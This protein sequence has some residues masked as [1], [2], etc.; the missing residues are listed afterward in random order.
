MR[1]KKRLTHRKNFGFAACPPFSPSSPRPP[2]DHARPAA[3]ALLAPSSSLR[4]PLHSRTGR[5]S[6][7]RVA[8]DVHRQT[9]TVR[10]AA[11]RTH[12]RREN[13]RPPFR[14]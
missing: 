9:F 2:V 1:R 14:R 6:L 12:L 8:G 3:A 11:R 5:A 13:A 10:R 4:S 7:A